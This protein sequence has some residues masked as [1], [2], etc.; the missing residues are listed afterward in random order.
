MS[1]IVLVRTKRANLVRILELVATQ[2]I[3]PGLAYKI[4]TSGGNAP[5]AK[6][7]PPEPLESTLMWD[8]EDFEDWED[9]DEGIE[10]RCLKETRT[11]YTH[12]TVH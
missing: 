2:A 4:I 9:D 8:D 1:D 7:G 12:R 3:G 11:P 5:A 10:L 6:V